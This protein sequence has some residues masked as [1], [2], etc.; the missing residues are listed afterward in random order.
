MHP[1]VELE[2]ALLTP[3]VR[4]SRE[5]LE[6]LLDPG[7]RE[8]GASGRVWTRDEIV[9]QLVDAVDEPPVEATDLAATE[10]APDVVLVTFQTGPRRAHR[11]SLWRRV[12]GQWRLL[13]HQGTP[14]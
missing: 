1:A 12:D 2:L 13:H 3:G 10:V 7:F 8:V 4:R 11:T 14:V 9:R 5:R 6:A